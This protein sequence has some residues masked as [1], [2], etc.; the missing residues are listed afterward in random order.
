MS[1]FVTGKKHIPFCGYSNAEDYLIN[2]HR[3]SHLSL[4]EG[5][6]LIQLFVSYHSKFLICREK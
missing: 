5:C 1:Q 2:M 6:Y 4:H 3:S